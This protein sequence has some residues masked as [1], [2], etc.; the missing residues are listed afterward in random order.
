MPETLRFSSTFY[1]DVVCLNEPGVQR[2]TA[3]YQPP[4]RLPC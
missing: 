4:D 2:Q 1:F 3:I